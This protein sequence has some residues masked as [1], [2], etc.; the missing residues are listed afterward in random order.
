MPA[1]DPAVWAGT[2]REQ[3]A[4]TVLAGALIN[5]RGDD[6]L[7]PVPARFDLL[8]FFQRHAVEMEDPRKFT[9]AGEF[10][11]SCNGEFDALEKWTGR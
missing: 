7:D 9:V 8:N 11:V 4:E 6:I 5:G 1:A 3:S 10:H 2:F